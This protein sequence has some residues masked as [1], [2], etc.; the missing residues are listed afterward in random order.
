[1]QLKSEPV[2]ADE[3]P[4][5]PPRKA[6]FFPLHRSWESHEEGR[7]GNKR[8]WHPYDTK[9]TWEFASP[10]FSR[11]PPNPSGHLLGKAPFVFKVPP[12]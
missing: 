9:R 3:W 10:A 6:K 7:L 2:N 12:D 1:M 5:Y 11:L 4:L 8:I